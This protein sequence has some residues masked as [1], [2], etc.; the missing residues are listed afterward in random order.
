MLVLR[1]TVR[2]AARNMLELGAAVRGILRI[3]LGLM[4]RF[5]WNHPV[6]II[7]IWETNTW[8]SAGA[9]LVSSSNSA[10]SLNLRSRTL[11][12]SKLV[13]DNNQPYRIHNNLEG[14]HIEL[15]LTS[16]L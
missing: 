16:R 13:T 11:I 9:T 2:G 14:S 12:F 3:P 10:P 6:N 7:G 5:T 8:D 1:T 15:A 4:W